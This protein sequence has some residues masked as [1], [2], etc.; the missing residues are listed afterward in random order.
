MWSDIG[1]PPG[2][3]LP[4]LFADFYNRKPEGVVNDRW[5]QLPKFLYNKW[6]RNYLARLLARGEPREMK[7]P[8][9]DFTTPEYATLD[10]IAEHKWE[11]CRGIGNSFGYNQFEGD[12]DYQKA[13]DLIRLLADIVSKNGN[14]L[15]NVGP[16]ADGSLHP[17]QVESLEGIGAWLTANGE[18]IYGTRPWKRFSEVGENGSEVRY[19]CK[20]ETLYAIVMTLPADGVV[21]LP[22]DAQGQVTLLETGASLPVE[23]R[24]AKSFVKLPANLNIPVLK[25]QK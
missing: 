8:H 1:Y 17:K 3:K 15:L 5:M 13:D 18:S 14:L 10:H 7:V 2:F 16:R 4:K 22:E 19:T 20:G 9:S 21:A 12:D 23:R 6:G 25:I 24:G 11:T